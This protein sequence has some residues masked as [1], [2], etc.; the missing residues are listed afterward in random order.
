MYYFAL[1]GSTSKSK[2]PERYIEL[3]NMDKSTA[4]E[5]IQNT[6]VMCRR[7]TALCASQFE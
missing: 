3:I 6:W 2:Q 7:A 5:E 1:F 4:A